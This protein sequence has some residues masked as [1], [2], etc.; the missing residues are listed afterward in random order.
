MFQIKESPYQM[1]IYSFET[2]LLVDYKSKKAR[3][4]YEN[5]INNQEFDERLG[6]NEKTLDKDKERRRLVEHIKQLDMPQGKKHELGVRYG[7]TRKQLK[8][9]EAK[10]EDR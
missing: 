9:I 2:D 5:A 7:L 4:F 6:I 3:E 8:R 10:G 1:P